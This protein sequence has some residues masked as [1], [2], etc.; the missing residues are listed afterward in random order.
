MIG[1]MIATDASP[2]NTGVLNITYAENSPARIGH[3]QPMLNND[4]QAAPQ[5]LTVKGST[6]SAV[7]AAE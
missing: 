4:S 2:G 5:T 6:G 1:Q 3:L 7:L